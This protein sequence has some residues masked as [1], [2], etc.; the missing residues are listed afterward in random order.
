MKQDLHKILDRVRKLLSLAENSPSEEEAASATA[1]AMELM[2]EYQLSE[3]LVRL[4]DPKKPRD[5]MVKARLEPNEDE[6]LA[7][8]EP[9]DEKATFRKRVAWREA[10]ASALAR[11]LGVH[12]YYQ[13]RSLGGK[14]RTDVRGFGRESAIQTWQYTFQYLARTIEE[15]ADKAWE[16]CD[17]KIY[18]GARAWKNAFRLGCAQRVALRISEKRFE[19]RE[20]RVAAARAADEAQASIND[21]VARNVTALQLL[22]EDEREVGDTYKQVSRG[23]GKTSS[24]GA[25]S[26]GSGYQA[27]KKAGEKVHLGGGRAG[28]GS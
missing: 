15:L 5:K 21:G 11:D 14:K 18:S 10:I 28:L 4:D 8:S 12:M 9:D 19:E 23:F 2:D 20:R 6:T 22:D 1:R 13:W 16:E 26:S 24:I 17:T 7:D 3:A 27:G 25:V